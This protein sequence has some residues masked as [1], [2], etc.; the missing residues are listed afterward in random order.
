MKQ[1]ELTP[2]TKEEADELIEKFY[3]DYKIPESIS[4]ERVK[5]WILQNS[6]GNPLGMREQ[7]KI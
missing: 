6:G 7:L 2:L 3:Q 5:K 1:V 4:T